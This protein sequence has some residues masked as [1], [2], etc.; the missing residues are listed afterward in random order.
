MRLFLSTMLFIAAIST[1]GLLR[2]QDEADLP[3]APNKKVLTEKQWKEVNESVDRGLAWLQTRQRPSGSFASIDYGQPAVTSFCLL[4]FMAQGESPSNGKYQQTLTKA[5]DYIMDQQQ[6]NGLLSAI[7]PSETPIPRDVDLKTL[8]VGS[9]YNHAISALA[10]T[11]AY[12]QC[13]PEQSKKLKPVIEDAIS[14]TLEMQRWKKTKK[15]D[16]GGWRY[17]TP[18]TAGDSDLSITGWQL[19]FL[20]SAKNA[21]FDVPKESIKAAVEYVKR[22]FLRREDRNVFGYMAGNY[23]RCSRAMAGAGLLALAHAG[24][25]GSDEANAAS[26]LILQNSFTQY[27]GGKLFNG[28]TGSDRYHYGLILCTQAMYQSGDKYWKPFFPPVV[29]V[30]LANQQQNGAWPPDKIDWKMGSCYSTSLCIL[31]LSA[32]N[33]LLPIFQR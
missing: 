6:A 3:R 13:T 18:R 10:L 9:V 11:E 4:A 20:R 5:V 28:T 8:A 31:S 2:A 15:E 27:N 17:L 16:Q 22:C 1:A 12:G 24:Y 29:E 21:G 25:H 14:A 19:M 30:L 32:P 23:S 7:A 33:Q 26:E